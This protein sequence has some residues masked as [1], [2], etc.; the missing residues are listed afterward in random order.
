MYGDEIEFKAILTKKE[1]KEIA[2]SSDIIHLCVS[3]SIL[4]RFY[5]HQKDPRATSMYKIIPWIEKEGKG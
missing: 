2:I 4:A 1:K 5:Q 3:T